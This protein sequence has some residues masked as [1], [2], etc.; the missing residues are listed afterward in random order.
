MSVTIAA[1]I[2]SWCT[3]SHCRAASSGLLKYRRLSH[4][5]CLNNPFPYP[6]HRNPTPHQIF[7]L[8]QNATEADIKARCLCVLLR[9][10]YNCILTES[11]LGPISADEAHA[12]FQAITAAYDKLRGKTPLGTI[13]GCDD[14]TG[15]KQHEYQT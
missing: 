7:H 2:R 9:I 8:P 3:T 15:S 14:I 11:S 6:S 4:A 5:T 1:N 12:R 10:I 13:P